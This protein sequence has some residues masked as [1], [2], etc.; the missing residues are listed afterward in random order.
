V[1]TGAEAATAS[2][3]GKGERLRVLLVTDYGTPTG[4]AELQ[5]LGLRDGLRERGHD[6]RLFTSS[7][8]DGTG[9]IE[10][11]Y[12][13]YGTTSP[14]RTPLQAANPFAFRGLWRTLA[15]FEPDVVH[16]RMFLT[17]LSPLILPLLAP[18]PSIYHVAWYRPVCPLGTKLLPDGSPCTVRAGKP[19]YSNG[20]L[21]LRD[22]V[23]LMG[24]RSLFRRWWRAFDR[25]VAISEAVKD[26]LLA[27]GIAPVDVMWNPVTDLGARPRLADPPTVGFAGRLVR[28]KGVDV[29]LRAFR[30]VGAELPGARLIVAG[31]GPER[32]ALTRLAGDL[33]LDASVEFTGHLPRAEAER[34][35]CAA[36]VQAVPSRWAEPFGNVVAEALMRG[37]A[38]VATD[39][40]GPGRVIQRGHTGELVPPD[41]PPALAA[42]LRPLLADPGHA[43]EMGRRARAFALQHLGAEAYLDSML[44]LY[45][46]LVA[47]AAPDPARP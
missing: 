15:D 47:K 4:G 37:T 28:E 17:Q 39:S 29:L 20:C 21:H 23:P 8:A 9:P 35:L 11:D 2:E 5:M 3:S 44:E 42:A 13:C 22:W 27:D 41:D 24:Q 1:T 36:W 10:S 26:E 7:A 30:E 34:R 31:D 38:V 14:L 43:E 18:F 32:K 19:C 40:G 12:R 6:A 16:V 46:S 25:I 45:R 33:R